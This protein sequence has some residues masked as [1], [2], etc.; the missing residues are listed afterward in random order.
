M[1]LFYIDESGNRDPKFTEDRYVYVLTAVGLFSDR[2][3]SF[4]EHLT[5]FKRKLAKDVSARTGISLDAFPL[6]ACEIKSNWIRQPKERAKRPFLAHLTAD[7][8]TELSDA[9]FRQLDHH[10]MV[11]ISVVIDKRKLHDYMDGMKLHRKA[12]E[13]LCER[14]ENYMIENHPKHKAMMITDDMSIQENHAL[15]VKHAHLMLNQ[16]T[17]G[18]NF[19]QLIEMP[20]FVRSEFSEGVQLADLCAYSV[21]RAMNTSDP[22]YSFFDR[23]KQYFY[24]SVRTKMSKIDGLK[25]FPDNSELKKIFE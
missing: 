24:S 23:I 2:W 3:K 1:Y 5:R 4:F 14:I 13:L 20:H 15:A 6:E 22:Q 25:I 9:Y 16:T 12:W 8:L 21:Y 17:A 11:V 7:E 19:R 18:V 10:K